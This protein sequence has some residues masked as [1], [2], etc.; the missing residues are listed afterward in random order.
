MFFYYIMISDKFELI[1]A[2]LS[3]LLWQI[4]GN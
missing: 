1:I 2:I 3:V 4:L